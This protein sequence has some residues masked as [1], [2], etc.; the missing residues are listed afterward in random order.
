MDNEEYFAFENQFRGPKENVSNRLEQYSK[1]IELVSLKSVNSTSLDIGCGRG[2]WLSFCESKGL[3]SFG[4]ENNLMMVQ[5]CRNAGFDVEEGDAL[6]GLRKIPDE[7]FSI[8]TAFH[9]IEHLTFD[10]LKE[11]FLE[12]YRVIAPGGV[13]LLES[14]SIDNISVSTK[15]FYTDPTHINHINPDALIYF[16]KNFGFDDSKYFYINGGPLQNSDPVNLTRLFNGIAQDICII[17]S[18]DISST[19]LYLSNSSSWSDFLNLGINTIE[20]SLEFDSA[21]NSKYNKMREILSK[22]KTENQIEI[23]SLSQQLLILEKKISI[24]ENSTIE[25]NKNK[26]RIEIWKEIVKRIPLTYRLYK[27]IKRII[28]LVMIDLFIKRFI[29]KIFVNTR[30]GSVIFRQIIRF[31]IK[32]NLVSFAEKCEKRYNRLRKKYY[33]SG[34]ID[35]SNYLEKHYYLNSQAK[36]I[37]KDL[38]S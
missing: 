10:Y 2:E 22:I 20:G 8:V 13:L 1:L 28:A 6:D 38:T 30:F 17:S 27:I 18:K 29:F 36:S 3:K 37:Y 5:E 11:L 34:I 16:L 7:S 12:C 23:Y 25:K 32:L 14:P 15:L 21:I 33:F 35:C 4:I 9:L 31:L 26:S 24:M 19:E